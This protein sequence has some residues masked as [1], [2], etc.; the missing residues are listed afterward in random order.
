MID[1]SG[2]RRLNYT[3]QQDVHKT[4]TNRR[5]VASN[6]NKIYWDDFF[7]QWVCD[8]KRC[9]GDD[10]EINCPKYPLRLIASSSLN[11]DLLFGRV[12][13]LEAYWD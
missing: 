5:I 9:G 6:N 13:A 7:K 2:V 11:Y 4:K 10:I 1:I 8:L 12:S 3:W